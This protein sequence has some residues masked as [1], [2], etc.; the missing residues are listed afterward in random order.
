MG[1]KKQIHTPQRLLEPTRARTTAAERKAER[2]AKKQRR[3]LI[4]GR[5][6]WGG[7]FGGRAAVEDT[8][9]VYTGPST[10]VGAVYPFL[11]GAGLPPRGVPVGRDVLTG[12]LVCVD[13]SGWTGRL[14]T[15]PGV[16]VMSQPGAGKSALVKRICL[17]YSAYGHMVVVP[18]DVKGEYTPLVEALGGSVVRIGAAGQ[19][20]NPLDSGPLKTHIASLPAKERVVLE[21]AVQ[22]RRLDALGALL[23]TRA[24]LGRQPSEVDWS[25][26]NTAVSLADGATADDPVIRD[27]IN[28]LRQGPQHLRDKLAASHEERYTDLTRS[29]I[30]GLE[31]LCDGPL[32][33]LFDGPTTA[34]IDLNAPAVSVDISALRSRGND[35]ISAGMIATW[36]YTYAAVDTARTIGVMNR[37]LV[38]PMDE[39][40]R[41][42]RSGPGLVDAMDS[43]SRL[44]RLY[45]DV[46]IFVT[47]SLLD[48]E[49][50]PTEEDR[51]KARGLMDRC[52]TW[53][54]GASTGEEL[55]RVTGKRALTEQ[56]RLI[57]Q[58]WA[59]ATS[60]GLDGT[61]QIHP[62]RGK[63]LIKIGTRPGIAAATELTAAEK[64]LYQTD[65]NTPAA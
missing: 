7:E 29:L 49:S 36:A 37:R 53:V 32:K 18:G 56:E 33:G 54:I 1:K 58:S 63:Y 57:I 40:W 35:V 22:G 47:H 16:W 64:R 21:E 25:A 30:A 26:L 43:I 55:Q 10:Q 51:V 65:A 39:M 3:R 13:P 5:L 8:G 31:N 23:A 9:T 34:A 59:S 12:E 61:D 11:L 20:L 15:N 2:Q 46:T 62:G 14:T 44:N 60:T 17:V 45:D 52:D 42:L 24:G 27:V 6:G 28:V 19:R 48:A 38:L 41:A 4:A 50:L